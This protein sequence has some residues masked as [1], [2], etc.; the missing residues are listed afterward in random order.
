MIEGIAAQIPQVLIPY[1]ADQPFNARTAHRLKVGRILKPTSINKRLPTLI[2]QLYQSSLYRRNCKQYAEQL[3]D[4]PDLAKACE[5][6][7]ELAGSLQ[8]QG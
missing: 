7:E 3:L 1:A 4:E 5:T 6:L 8:R 2:D